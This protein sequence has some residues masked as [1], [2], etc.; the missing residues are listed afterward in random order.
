MF[1]SFSGLSISNFPAQPSLCCAQ[2]SLLLLP[3]AEACLQAM[4]LHC[5]NLS[6]ASVSTREKIVHTHNLSRTPKNRVCYGHPSGPFEILAVKLGSGFTK[7]IISKAETIIKLFPAPCQTWF[8]APCISS[9]L[10]LD[11]YIAL[12]TW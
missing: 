12:P 3:T 2:L 11:F 5:R 4:V 10:S 9:T 1:L 8:S 7:T 6:R